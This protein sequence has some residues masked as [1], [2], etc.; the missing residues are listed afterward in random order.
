M[1]DHG[2]ILKRTLENYLKIYNI[3]MVDEE[4]FQGEMEKKFTNWD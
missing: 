4:Q 3:R 2:K 1:E